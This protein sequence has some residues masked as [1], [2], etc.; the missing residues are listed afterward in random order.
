MNLL[1]ETSDCVKHVDGVL[2]ILIEHN[3]VTY[4][5]TERDDDRLELSAR[6]RTLSVSPQCGGLEIGVKP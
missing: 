1:I 6:M 3:G 4:R 5:L 2:V